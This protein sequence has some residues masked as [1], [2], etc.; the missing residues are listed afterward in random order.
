MNGT[1]EESFGR[2]RSQ[3]QEMLSHRNEYMEKADLIVED[4]N[5][6]PCLI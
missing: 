2:T 4:W 6:K 1:R 3:T 5:Q